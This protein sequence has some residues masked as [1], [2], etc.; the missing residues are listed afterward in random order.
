MVRLCNTMRDKSLFHLSFKLTEVFFI[1]ATKAGKFQGGNFVLTIRIQISFFIF[2]FYEL[3]SFIY[4]FD[5]F[6]H[7]SFSFSMFNLFFDNII[8]THKFLQFFIQSNDYIK[9]F[10]P[11]C[12]SFLHCNTNSRVGFLTPIFNFIYFTLKPFNF[13]RNRFMNR[14]SLLHTSFSCLNSCNIV[15]MFTCF[16][17]PFL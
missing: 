15:S 4:S 12:C 3:Y 10:I 14:Q 11:L 17:L 5:Q 16:N 1:F 13:T 9:I 7:K 8:N 6:I 2:S